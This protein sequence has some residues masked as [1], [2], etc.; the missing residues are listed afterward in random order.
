MS[1]EEQIKTADELHAKEDVQA[2]Y[3]LLLRLD[4][5][6]PNTAA[7]LW[8]L[9]RANYIV[10]KEFVDDA[11]KREQHIRKGLELIEQ[12]YKL[13]QKDFAIPKWF[14]ILLGSMGE[15]ISTKEKIGNAYKIKEFFE[16]SIELKADDATTYHALGTW[17]W[18]VANVGFLE[19]GIASA[20]F[21]A[22][23]SSSYEECEKYLMKS[24]ELDPKQV[25]NALL[26]GDC[27]YAMKNWKEAKRFYTIASECPAVTVAAKKNVEEAKVKITKC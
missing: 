12:A 21:A 15:F 8:R 26:L 6:N 4:K 24:Y 25:Y 11:A 19:R 5:E 18:N 14:G 1:L 10:G 3:D 22:P 27:Y 7:V 17:C 20:L 13:D 23:P 16:K 2:T 9:A